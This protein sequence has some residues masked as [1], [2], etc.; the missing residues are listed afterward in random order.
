[1]LVKVPIHLQALPIIV[2]ISTKDSVG[3]AR[4][5]MK[6][7]HEAT[8]SELSPEIEEW[9][10]H[11]VPLLNIP[12]SLQ[13]S[14]QVLSKYDPDVQKNL[15]QLEEQL[16]SLLD[17]TFPLLPSETFQSSKIAMISEAYDNISPG[18][19]VYIRETNQAVVMFVLKHVIVHVNSGTPRLS[20]PKAK[21]NLTAELDETIYSASGSDIIK[22]GEQITATLAWVL[23]MPWGPVIDGGITAF[24][25]LFP[26][27]NSKSDAVK[28]MI[29]IAVKRLEDFMVQEEINK[30]VEM[31]KRF[32]DWLQANLIALSELKL[33]KNGD[34]YVDPLK[35]LLDD[36]Q[37]VVSPAGENLHDAVYS[38]EDH[39]D[40]DGV[41]DLYVSAIGL[42]LLARKMILLFEAQLAS[43]Y[44]QHDDTKFI[45]YQSL[46]LFDFALLESQIAGGKL[47]D[48][49]SILGFIQRVESYTEKTLADRLA[50]ITEVYRYN[51]RHQE[52]SGYG[53]TIAQCHWV[54]NWGWTFKD[55]L[56][57]DSDLTHFV[58]DTQ[59]GGDCC[60]GSHTVEHKD[61]ANANRQKLIDD[62]RKEYSSK[63][64]K[65]LKVARAWKGILDGW[66]SQQPPQPPSKAPKIADDKWSGTTGAEPWIDGA[67]LSY[68]IEFV[69]NKGP[70]GIGP[71]TDPVTLAGKAHPTLIDIPED[72]LK[73]ADRYRVYRRIEKPSGESITQ[74]V[75]IPKVSETTWKDNR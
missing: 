70:S 43:H 39:L 24:D 50:Q 64:E 65:G 13:D 10:S 59:E 72:P 42:Y 51:N 5:F 44:D 69:N 32:T 58:P 60:S 6:L 56:K 45:K 62:I 31:L 35:K 21:N 1:M 74:C 4:D 57:R 9:C 49:G 19:I 52:C 38:L 28:Q 22:V 26:S 71:W 30:S 37:K 25:F 55:N 8:L 12:F 68:A 41:F 7:W 18:T 40:K 27:E 53:G 63:F 34:S 48:G 47:P 2:S 14:G 46:W 23:P 54:D 73:L 3:Y 17:S 29:D 61:R 75:A 15:L 67:R 36:L 16:K 66:K 33:M 20:F 11:Y